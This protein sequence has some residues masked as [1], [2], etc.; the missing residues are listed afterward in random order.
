MLERLVWFSRRF[1]LK[2][3]NKKMKLTGIIVAAL[4]G[5]SLILFFSVQGCRNS[6]IE[7]EE[8]V[9]T[10]K[11]DIDVQLQRRVNLLTELSECVS[12]YDKHEAK[13]LKDVISKRGKNMSGSEA[14]DVM[15][16]IAAVA[17]RYPELQSQKNYSKLMNEC[18]LTENLVAQHKKAYNQSVND[19]RRYCRSF[20]AN[21]CLNIL[22]YEM[23]DY[24]RYKTDVTDTK[25]MVLFK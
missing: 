23:I 16:H 1:N 15:L 11:S 10:T 7:R 20:P 22:G 17:E 8:K 9:E 25:P 12:Q 5:I 24:E 6:A 18:S 4:F 21:V 2:Q 3:K 13:T 14:R 19:Y